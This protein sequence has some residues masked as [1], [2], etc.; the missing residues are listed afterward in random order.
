MSKLN[1]RTSTVLSVS[2]VE[3]CI[4]FLSKIYEKE[5]K[6]RLNK[7]KANSHKLLKTIDNYVNEDQYHKNNDNNENSTLETDLYDWFYESLLLRDFYYFIDFGGFR[8]CEYFDEIIFKCLGITTPIHP[9]LLGSFDQQT[10]IFEHCPLSCLSF[11]FLDDEVIFTTSAQTGKTFKK[12]D[13]HCYLN[14]KFNNRN[15]CER[16]Y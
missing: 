8:H 3:N 10:I 4:D 9:T 14:F 7:F 16:T 15:E 6:I 2:I 11:A 5:F 1:S 13:N 12:E